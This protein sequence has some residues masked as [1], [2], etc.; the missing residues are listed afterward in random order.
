M[1]YPPWI[2]EIGRE[3][4]RA[5][6]QAG[7]YTGY[8]TALFFGAV[9]WYGMSHG[10]LPPWPAF[11][12]LVIAKLTTNT[13]SWITLRARVL[14]L[15]FATLNIAA[16][17]FVMTGGVYLTGGPHSPLLPIYFIE[18]AVMALL[19]N[20]GLTIVT[21]TASFILFS[22]MCGLILAGVLPLLR[23]PSEI[24][25]SLT[26]PLLATLL[27]CFAMSTLAP[28]AYIALIV[29]RLRAKETVLEERERQ[30]LEAAREKSQFMVNVTHELRT[31]LH[32]ILGLSDLLRD[33]V[34][35][36]V[37]P[38]QIEAVQGIEQSA[39]GLL[40]MVDSLLF[41][42]RAEAAKMELTL[43]VVQPSEVVNRVAA[44]GRWLR[45]RKELAI[46]VSAPDDLPSLQTDR[47]K[48]A[49]ILL[50]LVANAIK[51]T[52]EG[53]TVSVSACAAGEGVEIAVT[54]TG[55]GIPEDEVAHIFD[56]FHQVDGSASRTYGGA[57]LGL[58]VVRR[59]AGVL[60]GDVRVKTKEGEGSTFTLRLPLRMG[61]AAPILATSA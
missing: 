56:E 46:E 44:A 5:N 36:P 14:H 34:Y 28:G 39:R 38:E 61:S 23:T 21:I 11:A 25:G 35:G 22:V 49:Q 2:A 3:S 48:L 60:G 42:A 8:G 20:L 57:G 9:V 32:G 58:A 17:L 40:E 45:G 24:V 1:R 52:P 13:L 33:R 27:A 7:I 10:V 55:I 43:G 18:V 26:V 50:N 59:L 53:G 30:L 16:D 31:P 19:T 54:D 12:W 41:L 47:G 51:F 29:Q 15:E 4:F 6:V 37:T